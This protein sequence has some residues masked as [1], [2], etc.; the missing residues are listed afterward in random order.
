MVSIRSD[1][2]GGF[3]A[4]IED[5]KTE[6][7]EV[8]VSHYIFDDRYEVLYENT[9]LNE[10]PKF[11]L[12]PRGSTALLDAIG[13]TI[14]TRGAYYAS[15]PEEERP[16]KVLFVITTDGEENSSQEFSLERIREMITHQTSV[17]KWQFVFLA[18]NQDAIQAG[19]DMGISMDCALTFANNSKGTE[20]A[21]LSLSSKAK[22]YRSMT[23]SAASFAFDDTDRS[24]QEEA[25][26]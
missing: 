6:P 21:Y 18:S 9:P 3:N 7:G 13:R 16:E 25:G 17:Y 12:T 23:P 15:L 8:R 10:V 14:V 19:A 11:V 22:A 5:Q 4:F 24:L 20:S 26:L 1:A 2:E